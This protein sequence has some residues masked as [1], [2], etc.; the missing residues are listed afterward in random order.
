M[1]TRTLRVLA[2]LHFSCILILGIASQLSP[3]KDVRISSYS[4]G[5]LL[6]GKNIFGAP[7]LTFFNDW[8]ELN[9][10]LE[11]NSLTFLTREPATNLGYG[12]SYRPSVIEISKR[13][14]HYALVWASQVNRG[15]FPHVIHTPDMETAKLFARALQTGD[16]SPSTFGFS[17]S[18][19]K[20]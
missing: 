3:Q 20:L 10:H 9:S 13:N 19:Q 16:V 7:S 14:N 17:I 18:L 8:S 2:Y 11:K 15:S 4:D 1:N 12:L 5:I 6:S